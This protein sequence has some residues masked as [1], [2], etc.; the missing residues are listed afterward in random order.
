MT[1]VTEIAKQA[2]S[3]GNSEEEK[4]FVARM[5]ERLASGKSFRL[6]AQMKGGSIANFQGV[7]NPDHVERLRLVITEGGEIAET[8]FW[9]P[10]DVNNYYDLFLE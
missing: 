7:T 2:E 1:V 9:K 5:R 8:P 10:I 6:E 3:V 4:R